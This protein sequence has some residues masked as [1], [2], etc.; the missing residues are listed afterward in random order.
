[1]LRRPS[2]RPERVAAAGRRAGAGSDVFAAQAARLAARRS[3]AACRGFCASRHRLHQG[4]P[5]ASRAGLFAVPGTPRSG[6]ARV[7]KPR[8]KKRPGGALC[9]KPVR[10]SRH[11]AIPDRGRE[12]R[13]RR[14]GHGRADDRRGFQFSSAHMRESD[15][16]FH[17]PSHP[18]RD[19]A[20]CSSAAARQA[21]PH[22]GSRRGHLPELWRTLRLLPR[23]LP[24][25]RACGLGRVRRLAPRR[26][27]AGRR[28]AHRSRGRDA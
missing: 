16:R 1:M 3:R 13:R 11:H 22:P 27:G 24:G 5:R 14:Y 15:R 4:R 12:G 6:S 9:A 8:A 10:R 23:Y 2:P 21:V 7:A 17:C 26:A 25:P 20:D 18:G 28:H 19:D